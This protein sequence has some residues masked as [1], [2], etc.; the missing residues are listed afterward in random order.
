[1]S[2]KTKFIDVDVQKIHDNIGRRDEETISEI[3][4]EALSELGYVANDNLISWSWS[5]EVSVEVQDNDS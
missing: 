1:M 2:I 5:I 4:N 3:V